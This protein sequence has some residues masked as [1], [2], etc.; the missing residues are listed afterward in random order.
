LITYQD[1]V[2]LANYY[3]LQPA[4]VTDCG[5]DA[6]CLRADICSTTYGPPDGLITYQDYVW[7]ANYYPLQPA[8]VTECC[9]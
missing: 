4:T 8:T 2:W 1:Y 7:L 6:A 9:P 5:A 3:P